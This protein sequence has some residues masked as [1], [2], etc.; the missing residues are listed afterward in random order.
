MI[1]FLD[2][3]YNIHLKNDLQNNNMISDQCIIDQLESLRE[4]KA[5][6]ETRDAKKIA[7]VVF[8]VSTPSG[9]P[10]VSFEPKQV[11]RSDITKKSSGH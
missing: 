8:S 7:A 9:L 4:E 3:E 11:R 1:F 2:E 5:I 6:G 10:T